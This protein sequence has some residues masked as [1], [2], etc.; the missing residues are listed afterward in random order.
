MPGGGSPDPGAGGTQHPRPRSA[1]CA[2]RQGELHRETRPSNVSARGQQRCCSLVATIATV[3]CAPPTA[4]A[5]TAATP[6][7]PGLAFYTPP[8]TP[9]SGVHGDLVSYRTTTVAL[10]T[11]APAVNAWNVLYQSTDSNG[12][13]NYVTG[14]V[15]V[16]TAP[17]TGTR[18][19]ISYAV[20][21][22]GLAQRCAPSL[23]LA[24]GTDYER[25]N[26]VAALGKGYAVLISDY[27]GYTTGSTPTYTVG[28]AEGNAVLDIVR[29]AAQVPN[30]RHLGIGARRAL[31]LLAGRP[32]GG[33]GRP[34]PAHV[35]AERAAQGRGG[36]WRARRPPPDGRLPRR[37][38][39]CRLRLRVD[40]RP[41]H[42]VPEPADR[43]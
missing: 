41:R 18:P 5:S 20:G 25:D 14:T 21:T 22:H 38:H 11:G 27:A 10:G 24:G 37:R 2:H 4:E 30:S 6:G 26:I 8:S 9:P 33:V 42:R 17:Y 3:L 28:K 23:Q 40:H 36:R 13:A 29:A 31:G 16:P 1:R 19:V 35:R 43:R 15:L 7:P 12:K 39:R 32:G 34:A